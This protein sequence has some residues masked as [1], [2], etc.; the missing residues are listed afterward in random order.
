M[1]DAKDYG[2]ETP[3]DEALEL[4]RHSWRNWVLLASASVLTTVGLATAIPPL[5]NARVENVW[6]WVNTD[7]VLLVGISLA[8]F[9]FVSYLSQQQLQAG[10]TRRRL[11]QLQEE[12]NERTR[13]SYSRL[14]GLFNVSRLIGAEIHLE[15]VF[16]CITKMCTQTFEC[17][18]ASLMLYDRQS[19]DLIVRSTS[20]Q[21]GAGTVLG[22]RQ[23]V[24]TGISG[25]VAKYR[26]P[27]LIREPAD[28]EKYPGLE[29]EMRYVA[30]SMVVPIIAG[31]E[32]VGVLN[33]SSNAPDIDY[34]EEDLRIL[35]VF[36]ENAGTFIRLKT[37]ADWIKESV[38]LS[39]QCPRFQGDCLPETKDL[40]MVE[41]IADTC[42]RP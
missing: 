25:W 11:Q 9:V 10:A 26:K 29:A 8:M 2:T 41:N 14:L 31:N 21:S 22:L 4:E 12:A 6:P 15:G 39:R 24:G 5:L 40:T 38:R 33:V 27:I 19:D 37:Q 17:Q 36:A 42:R 1:Y 16:D 13:R 20:M 18:R 3:P 34:S 28:I 7:L 30:A 32:L 35:W 23:K